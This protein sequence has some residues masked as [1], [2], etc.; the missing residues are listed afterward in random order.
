M[1]VWLLILFSAKAAPPANKGPQARIDT[2]E[3]NCIMWWHKHHTINKW[4]RKWI[5]CRWENNYWPMDTSR[6]H[7][8]CV[9][10]PVL[11]S[12]V[13]ELA[14]GAGSKRKCLCEKGGDIQN[15]SHFLTASDEWR[16]GR[17]KEKPFERKWPVVAMVWP[18][19]LCALMHATICEFIDSSIHLIDQL[20]QRKRRGWNK[21]S[22][23]YIIQVTWIKL[24]LLFFRCHSIAFS[25]ENRHTHINLR[26]ERDTEKLSTCCEWFFLFLWWKGHTS[27]DREKEK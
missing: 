17:E 6:T 1:S 4:T 19:F 13:L 20:G 25:D 21:L 7:R 22:E 8:V 14:E 3:T 23:T 10:V 15:N 2:R 9:C 26:E 5:A 24:L 16:K 18:S 27:T 12:R 11:S